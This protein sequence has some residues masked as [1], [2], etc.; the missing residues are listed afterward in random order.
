VA[1]GLYHRCALDAAGAAYCWG[2][3]D[4]GRLGDG[5]T[6]ART[7]PVP[8]SGGVVFVSLTA[9]ATHT[10]GLDTAGHAW[11][12]G[13]NGRSAL[14]DG[15]TEVEQHVP[16]AVAAPTGGSPLTFSLL[17][18]GWIHTCGLGTDGVAWCWGDNTEGEL[19][20]L[21]PLGS[22]RPTR[23]AGGRLFRALSAEALHT[24]ALASDGAAYCWGKNDEG[25]L[26]TGTTTASATPVA[27][28]GG[29]RYTAIAASGLDGPDS[30]TCA[31]TTTGM[32]CWGDNTAGQLGDGTTT[33]RLTPSV[34]AGTVFERLAGGLQFTC[35][36]TSAGTAWCW[37][38]NPRGELGNGTTTSQ[39]S[40]SD[41]RPKATEP[42]AGSSCSTSCSSPSPP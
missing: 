11:C 19:G 10:C 24:C 1:G 7:S 27:V 35:G 9:G 36:L 42:S 21:T 5:T 12:W 41:S 26:G 34:V 38:T 32:G 25:E 29:F 28:A 23:V 40:P 37:G 17:T 15:T 3:N 6:T 13:N 4:Q 16:V 8:V 31:A 2:V 22:N 39:S 33:D 20:N 30:H 14:G 18:A